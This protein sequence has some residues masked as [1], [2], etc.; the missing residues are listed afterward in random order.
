MMARVPEVER[1]RKQLFFLL[2]ESGSLLGA[3]VFTQFVRRERVT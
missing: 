2:G 1:S 3:Q